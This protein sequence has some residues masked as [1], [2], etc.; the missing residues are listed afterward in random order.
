MK[1]NITGC[2]GLLAR[3]TV[4]LLVAGAVSL[5]GCTMKNQDAPGLTGPSEFATALSITAS[6]D[7][8]PQDGTSQSVVTLV[9]RGPSGQPV[10]GLSLRVDI[11]VNGVVADFGRLSARNIATDS[12]GRATVLYTA[13]N[14][15]LPVDQGTVVAIMLT[16]IGTDYGSSAARTVNIRLMPPG[17]ILPPN[18]APVAQFVFSPATPSQGQTIVFDAS[19]STDPD[20][21]DTIVSYSWSF[22]DGNTRSGKVV[23]IAYNTP[24]TYAVTLT[25]T[26]D[27]GLSASRTQSFTVGSVTNPVSFTFSP[28]SPVIGELVTFMAI[29]SPAI[30]SVSSYTWNFGDGPAEVSTPTGT[31]TYTFPAERTYVVRLTVV[32][33]GTTYVVTRDVA[34]GAP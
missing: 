31:A 34:V 4:T 27:R 22:S 5:T 7:I 10:S 3:S 26:D 32:A 30:G 33:D 13:P 17:V 2:S 1:H 19:G 20:G 12:S 21:N 16:P 9:A 14:V 28:T 8:L 25:V 29:V 23:T 15:T 18:G 6:P 24:G 11:V